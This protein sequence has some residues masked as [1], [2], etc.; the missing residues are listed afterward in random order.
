MLLPRAGGPQTPQAPPGAATGA[1]K[2]KPRPAPAPFLPQLSVRSEASEAAHAFAGAPS[3]RDDED[4]MASMLSSLMGTEAAPVAQ[5]W[6]APGATLGSQHMLKHQAPTAR[7]S[8]Y[9]Q[10][11]IVVQSKSSGIVFG[12]VVGCTNECACQSSCQPSPGFR[13]QMSASS[14]WAVACLAVARQA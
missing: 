7:L 11:S 8:H 6:E 3:E 13:P 10:V 2:P 1:H 9:Y 12:P 5:S 4:E 14:S